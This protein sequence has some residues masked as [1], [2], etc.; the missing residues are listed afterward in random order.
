[1]EDVATAEISRTQV[2][3]WAHHGVQLVDGRTVTAEL[4]EQTIAEEMSVIAEEVGDAR[5]RE[6]RFVEA[7][8]LFHDLCTA[9]TLAP[10]LTNPAYE[11][12][13]A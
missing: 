5:M 7:R 12:L 1:M 2:W 6:G 3:Q 11:I 4:V 9:S 13:E 8:A 10:F